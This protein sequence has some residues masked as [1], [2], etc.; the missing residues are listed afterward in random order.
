MYSIA[1]LIKNLKSIIHNQ[2]VTFGS[3][4]CSLKGD[5]TQH[6]KGMRFVAQYNSK[7]SPYK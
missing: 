5:E 3:R 4:R 6:Q 1:F 2:I 7:L